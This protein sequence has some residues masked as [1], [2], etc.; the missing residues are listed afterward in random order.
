ME[1]KFTYDY[2][3]CGA[4]AQFTVKPVSCR[5]LKQDLCADIIILYNND[6]HSWT[7]EN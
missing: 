2:I 1:I 7:S 6:G 3:N 5:H 4:T